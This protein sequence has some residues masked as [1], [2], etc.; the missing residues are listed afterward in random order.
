MNLLK[1]LEPT[2]TVAPHR[3]FKIRNKSIQFRK[4]QQPWKSP[5]TALSILHHFAVDRDFTCL[6]VKLVALL[7]AS[8]GERLLYLSELRIYKSHLL[9]ENFINSM[10]LEHRC[11][12]SILPSAVLQLSWHT[13]ETLIYLSPWPLMF[14]YSVKVSVRWFKTHAVGSSLSSVNA[15]RPGRVSAGM[16]ASSCSPDELLQ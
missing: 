6:L 1:S 13:C 15:T 16:A 14:I 2:A 12:D 9:W 4:F 8:H 3:L 7:W 10:Q 5:R 11:K